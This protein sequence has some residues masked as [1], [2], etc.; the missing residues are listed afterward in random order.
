MHLAKARRIDGNYVLIFVLTSYA[1]RALTVFQT[2]FSL[3]I[4][5]DQ[6]KNRKETTVPM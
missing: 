6:H 5:A 1:M 3:S 4:T 2:S